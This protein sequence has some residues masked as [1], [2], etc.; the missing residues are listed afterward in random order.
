[1]HAR[2]LAAAGQRRH[3]L[4]ALD[5]AHTQITGALDELELAGTHQR[6]NTVRRVRRFS[7]ADSAGRS[8]PD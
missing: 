3:A 5:R 2:A 1:M 7:D 8:K 4:A 6:N